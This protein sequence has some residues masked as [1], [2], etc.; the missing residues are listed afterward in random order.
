MALPSVH[1]GY[2]PA[3]PLVP[4]IP[5]PTPKRLHTQKAMTI[6]VGVLANGGVVL[7]ADTQLTIP[8]FWKGEGGKIMA[9]ARRKPPTGVLAVTGA[10]NI[11]EYLHGLGDDLTRDFLLGLHDANK[12]AAYE[13]FGRVLRRFYRRHVA[14][15]TG[16]PPVVDVLM[17]Y[18]R[19]D[20]I[21]LWQSSRNLLIEQTEYGAVGIGSFAANAWLGRM[22]RGRQDI[23]AAVVTA[24]FAAAVA[25]ESV[26]G[27]GKFTHVL[28][29]RGRA[30][31]A[32]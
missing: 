23:P 14:P 7:A 1:P 2:P 5:R 6:A 16:E 21:A 18:Q 3:R 29:G 31:L 9:T 10:T 22:W 26:D 25:K 15:I 27:C 24:V 17:A 4:R 30:L 11:Y 32:D 8:S 28:G 12:E 13:R 19:G 20:E